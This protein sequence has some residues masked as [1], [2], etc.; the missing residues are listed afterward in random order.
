MTRLASIPF[1]SVIVRT[2]QQRDLLGTCLRCLFEQDYPREQ[3]EIIV[4][5][6]GSTDG[7]QELVVS[8]SSPLVLRY[9]RLHRVGRAKAA[10]EGARAARGDVLL[11]L[12]GDTW[13][14][15]RLVSC[16]ARHYTGDL[17]VAVMGPQ[18]TPVEAL[19][20]NQF[21]QTR[22]LYSIAEA[23]PRRKVSP[24]EVGDN[25][26]S[27]RATDFWAVGGFDENFEGYGWFDR[28][29]G[30]RL[31]RHGVHLR[32]DPE[33]VADHFHIETL[34][35]V[36]QK[37][38]ESGRG[39]V[40]LWRKHGRSFSIG[41]ILE[42]HPVLLPL[43]WLVYRQKLISAIVWRVLKLAERRD[44]RPLLTLCYTHLVWEAYYEGVFAALHREAH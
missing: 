15:R 27:L 9:I 22:F 16:H 43:K 31:V 44:I 40:Y 6:D 25:N 13:A 35:S 30:L 39:A 36:R 34:E 4:V 8:L 32:Y 38:R 24:L 18:R 41:M 12:N 29:L 14:D 17:P 37:M 20:A 2:Y 23:V 1:I 33:A 10:N 3:M 5:D 26:L 19:A 21:M 7:T 42:I 28:D 11:F